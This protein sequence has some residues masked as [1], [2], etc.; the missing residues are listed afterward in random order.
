MAKLHVMAALLGI[1]VD[2]FFGGHAAAERCGEVSECLRLW[3]KIKTADGHHQ[4]LEYLR[5]LADE[6]K[7]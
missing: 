1:P 5:E 3:D 7:T 2:S 6:P 4:A